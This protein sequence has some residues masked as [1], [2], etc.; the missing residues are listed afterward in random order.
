MDND[1]YLPLVGKNECVGKQQTPATAAMTLICNLRA[2]IHRYTR[3]YK[4]LDIGV[5]TGAARDGLVDL[6]ELAAPGGATFLVLACRIC[7]KKHS[8][9]TTNVVQVT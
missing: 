4:G 9:S 3:H 5:T 6:P 1:D 8:N 7:V 2:T